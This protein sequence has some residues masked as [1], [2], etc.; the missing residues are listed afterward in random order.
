MRIRDWEP[1]RRHQVAHWLRHIC[2]THQPKT[3]SDL[4][5]V[6]EREAAVEINIEGDRVAQAQALMDARDDW[7]GLMTAARFLIVAPQRLR[8]IVRLRFWG[9]GG[10]PNYIL[11][12]PGEV[13]EAVHLSELDNEHRKSLNRAQKRAGS[14]LIVPF[15]RGDHIHWGLLGQDLEAL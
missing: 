2:D 14:D 5:V 10:P 4:I 8:V 7:E 12:E 13:V 9:P 11:V 6:A 15:R 3:P 1:K